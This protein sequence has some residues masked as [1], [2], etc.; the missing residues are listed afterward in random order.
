M[1][2]ERNIY[3]AARD[4]A[5]GISG[6]AA[7]RGAANPNEAD[8]ERPHH[9]RARSVRAVWARWI[10]LLQESHAAARMRLSEIGARQT[11]RGALDPGY[12]HGPIPAGHGRRDG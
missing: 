1:P 11:C 4:D 6:R 9:E 2:G 12:Q 5:A 3:S 7:I 10:R 8:P